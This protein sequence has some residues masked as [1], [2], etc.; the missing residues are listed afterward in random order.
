MHKPTH[1]RLLILLVLLIAIFTLA[2]HAGAQTVG[3]FTATLPSAPLAPGATGTIVIQVQTGGQPVNGAEIHLDFDPAVI[4]VTGMTA[5]NT[6]PLPLVAPVVNNTLGQIDYAAGTVSNFPTANFD[7]LTIQFSAV[8]PGSTTLRIP[9]SPVPRRSDITAGTRSI[10]T[11]TGVINLGTI[12]VAGPATA[13]PL[14]ATAT[15]V[16]T[17]VPP[18]VEPS[19]IPPTP[20]T[21]PSGPRLDIA[22][23]P[24]DPVAGDIL[25]VSIIARQIVGLYGLEAVC[26]VD[27]ASVQAGALG[28]SDI[29]T[30]ANSF[31]VNGNYQATGSWSIAA[32][33]L[34]PAPSFDGTGTA[35]TLM[36]PLNAVSSFN[37]TCQALAVDRNGQTL[38]R[39]TLTLSVAVGGPLVTP[40]PTIEPTIA[41]T[42][43]PTVEPTVVPPTVVPPTLTPEPT[44]TVAPTQPPVSGSVQG[45]V[46]FQR[47]TDHS[48]IM[49]TLLAGG[50]T[51][52]T[53]AQGQTNADGSFRFD[54]V[55]AG[56]Y[57]L[58]IFGASHLSAVYSFTVDAAGITLRTVTLLAGDTDSNNTINLADA[59]LIGANLQLT[60]PPAPPAA[61][62]NA[63]AQ[64]N[65][66]DLVL[67]GSNFGTTGP[68][69]IGP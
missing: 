14:P 9:Q 1:S 54:N 60:V 36:Y 22:V 69:L 8:A 38:T 28:A 24:T 48:G 23:A 41:P 61:D 62:L 18:T 30:S 49:L 11:Q 31:I 43:Q 19:V 53:F 29:F 6:L 44:A 32:S 7:L 59:A 20:T 55:P 26:T 46:N 33:L 15:L 16:P 50:P 45:I 3:G 68:V 67:V 13:T 12:T 51:G 39:S 63:D 27:P 35:F 56:A 40:E 10:F 21:P 2:A 4:Q 37:I 58:Q 17:T 34:N 64:I 57:A 42:G 5:H 66:I 65:I 25:S 47:K 52:T